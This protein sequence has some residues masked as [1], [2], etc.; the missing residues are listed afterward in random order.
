MMDNQLGTRAFLGASS[1]G[2]EA[3]LRPAGAAAGEGRA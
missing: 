3:G 2:G 1:G